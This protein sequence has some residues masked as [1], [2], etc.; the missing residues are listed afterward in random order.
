M[1]KREGAVSRF[2][3]DSRILLHQVKK[4][5]QLGGWRLWRV[6]PAKGAQVR[7]LDP[8]KGTQLQRLK[9]LNRARKACSVRLVGLQR[10]VSRFAACG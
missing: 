1:Y 5:V 6:E 8:P 4:I 2:V 10:A 3:E 7:R 9:Q